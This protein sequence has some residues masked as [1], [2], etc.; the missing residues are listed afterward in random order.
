MWL[1]DFE[2]SGKFGLI[3]Y[4]LVC[5]F[6]LLFLGLFAY[7]CLVVRLLRGWLDWLRL[8][9]EHHFEVSCL[10]VGFWWISASGVGTSESL[11]SGFLN[12]VCFVMGFLGLGWI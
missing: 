4:V 8:V 5:F 9:G 1:F 12:L 10:E 11:G 7:V 2:V 3:V 6:V